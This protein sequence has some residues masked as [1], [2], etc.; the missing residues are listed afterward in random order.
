[1]VSRP[2][3]D[4]LTRL[5]DQWVDGEISQEEIRELEAA[6]LESA[7]ARR[8]FWRQAGFHG[9]LHEAA[10]MKF[11]ADGSS[12][13]P[14]RE[15]GIPSDRTGLLRR[16][17]AG[18][19][20]RRVLWM[21]GG[22]CAAALALLVGGGS[23]GSLMTSL[24]LARAERI[25]ALMPAP[26]ELFSDGFESPP[27]PAADYLPTTVN[28]WSGDVTSVTTAEERAGA[29]VLPRSGNR[30]LR[31]VATHPANEPYDAV[32]SEVWRFIDLEELRSLAGSHDINIELAAWF[33]GVPAEPGRRPLCGLTAIAMDAAPGQAHESMWLT[34]S[35]FLK[36]DDPASVSRPI[37]AAEVKERI[38]DDPASWQRIATVVAVP[39][40][41]RYLLLHCYVVDR[42][43]AAQ[44]AAERLPGQ[45]MDDVTVT[46]LPM[47]HPRRYDS[48]ARHHRP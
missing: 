14:A 34:K 9:L 42:S 29:H 35:L 4:R 48:F 28:Q 26:L 18:M 5:I 38:D 2:F 11:A 22:V 6:L 16:N 19:G 32:A 47:R 45:Y 8:H 12:V 17:G 13:Q 27:E 30:M 43:E 23:M 44:A 40:S 33:N 37:A 36:P 7:E 10:R 3:A 20:R 15:A 1:M 21:R 39:A 24:S 25:V 46:V 41:A 31:F